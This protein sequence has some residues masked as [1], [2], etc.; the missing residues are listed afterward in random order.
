MCYRLWIFTFVKFHHTLFRNLVVLCCILSRFGLVL[1]STAT[2]SAANQTSSHFPRFPFHLARSQVALIPLRFVFPFRSKPH[3]FFS[4]PEWVRILPD[5][6]LMKVVHSHV[7]AS[8]WCS[9]LST[10]FCFIPEQGLNGNMKRNVSVYSSGLRNKCLIFTR[11][12]FSSSDYVIDTGMHFNLNHCNSL[13][14]FVCTSPAKT[15]I[16]SLTH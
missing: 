8:R 14:K 3:L 6:P 15:V 11:I 4:P 12:L 1:P 10:S 5:G 2:A 13:C 7:T 16:Y 9:F